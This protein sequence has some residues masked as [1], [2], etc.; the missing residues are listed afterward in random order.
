MKLTT[1]WQVTIPQKIREH[2]SLAA[3]GDVGFGRTVFN[4]RL[5]LPRVDFLSDALRCAVVY[6]SL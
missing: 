6:A 4:S 5:G 3:N 2:L 1:E